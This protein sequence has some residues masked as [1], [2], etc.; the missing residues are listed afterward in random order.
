MEK[1]IVNPKLE[2]LNI[3][4]RALWTVCKAAR[5][6]YNSESKD[7]P[8]KRRKFIE[9][10]LDKKHESVIEHISINFVLSNVSRACVNQIERHRIGSYSQLSQRYVKMDKAVFL[11]PKSV[12][13]LDKS[14]QKEV[15]DHLDKTRSLY[16]KL[17]ENGMFAEDARYILPEG[18]ETRVFFT[19]NLRQARHFLNLRMD[20][21][22]QEEVRLVALQ[23]YE[24]LNKNCSWVVKD[25]KK[26]YK[27][28]YNATMLN[29][30]KK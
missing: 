18:T 29:E 20:M 5:T 1:N 30:T 16:K 22:A 27:E 21:H 23:M 7:I 28:V 25:F 12:L 15:Y 17:L 24:I 4:K 6:C 3:N 26:R 9:N 13:K 11:L 19:Y 8:R 14:V 2:A 10:L